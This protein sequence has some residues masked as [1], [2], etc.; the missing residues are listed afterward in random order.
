MDLRVEYYY[1]DEAR[2]WS[3]RVPG[4]RI[5]GGGQDTR[6]EAEQAAVEAILFTLETDNQQA[7]ITDN[8][9]IGHV[10]VTVE[11]AS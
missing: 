10:R 7:P 6:K 11:A 9:Q 8:T 2:H 3:F 4:L 1:D 5:V